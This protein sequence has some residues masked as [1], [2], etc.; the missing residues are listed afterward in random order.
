MNHVEVRGA[1]IRYA[2]SGQRLHRCV[3]GDAGVVDQRPEPAGVGGDAV[4]ERRDVGLDG[5][6]QDDRFDAVGAQPG[7]V[8][9]PTNAGKHV[10]A[11]PGQLAGGGGPHPGGR[12]GHDDELSF[13]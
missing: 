11:L 9:R 10:E 6:V 2:G 5:D 8:L 3:D 13:S 1:R 12:S 7:R 4:R